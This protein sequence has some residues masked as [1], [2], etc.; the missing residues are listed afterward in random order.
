MDQEFKNLTLRD[1][2]L[3]R[4]KIQKFLD[5]TYR[6]AECAVENLFRNQGDP[7]FLKNLDEM[8]SV[9]K[10]C[11]ERLVNVVNL[12]PELHTLEPD[13][14]VHKLFLYHIISHDNI[15]TLLIYLEKNRGKDQVRADYTES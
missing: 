5:E 13:T 9:L 2:R 14:K 15:D 1:I 12:I 11:R 6:E 10:V 8:N 7:D 4:D 3:H